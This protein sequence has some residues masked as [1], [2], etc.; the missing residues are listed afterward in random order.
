MGEKVVS[1]AGAIVSVAMITAL[2]SSPNTASA[3]RALGAAFSGSIRAALGQPSG[4]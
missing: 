1:V 2:V 4:L 3:L